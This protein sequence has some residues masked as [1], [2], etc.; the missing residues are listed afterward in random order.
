MRDAPKHNLPIRPTSFIGREKELTQIGSQLEESECRLLS[1][2]GVGGIGKTSLAIK[3][4]SEQVDHYSDG[5][6]LVE[7]ANM[8]D[9]DLLSQQVASVFGVTSHISS[10]DREEDEV[11]FDFLKD[12][13]LLLV[14]D[15]CEHLIEASAD[16]AVKMLNG[17]PFIK[18]LAT[19]RETL[20]IPGEQLFH[21]P[22]LSLPAG[23]S[24][25]LQLETFE[26]VQLFVDRAISVN[27][28]FELTDQ[29]RIA[30]L[31]ICRLLDGIPLAIELAAARVTVLSPDQIAERLED[32]FALLKSGQRTALP[33]HQTLQATMDWSYDLLNEEERSLFRQLSVFAGGWTLVS[34]ERV[35]DWP[36]TTGADYL[37]ELAHLVDKSLVVVER[38]NGTVRYKMLETVRQYAG[39]RLSEAGEAERVRRRHALYFLALAEDLEPQLR[40]HN[41]M[42]C[43]DLFEAEHEN[44]RSAMRRALEDGEADLALRLIATL[45]WFWFMRGYWKDVQR[46]LPM[47]LDL[48]TETDPLNR[49][50]AIIKTGG[51][52]IIR[53][54]VEGNVDLIEEALEIC[55]END[56][57][58]GVA[59]CFTFL[60]MVYGYRSEIDGAYEYLS[61]SVERFRKLGDEWG[62]AWSLRYLSF[63]TR[64][65]IGLDETKRL[66]E[67]SISRFKKIGDLWNAAHS[68]YLL[69]SSVFVECE[70]QR[71]EHAFSEG[72]QMCQTISDEVMGVHN[73]AGM[74]M[75]SFANGDLEQ[76]ESYFLEVSDVFQRIGDVN[77][78]AQARGFLA[79]LW[80]LMDDLNK[81]IGYLNE[82]IQGYIHLKRNLG[83]VT[84][85]V[86]FARVAIYQE[87]FQ[88]ATRLLGFSDSW[89]TKQAFPFSPYYQLSFDE[90]VRNS[91]EALGEE[92]FEQAWSKGQEMDLEGA[93][94]FAMKEFPS[95]T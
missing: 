14:M 15:N 84:S 64:R 40:G 35:V 85:L 43:L 41:Q 91:K 17:C 81:A 63:M 39:I 18:I 62:I 38:K 36:D 61:E 1:L 72:Y 48:K 42:D 52:E 8:A 25:D 79:E 58:E 83:I 12:K 68:L 82:S 3:Y 74:G 10:E 45:G 11:L 77:C 73:R 93:I 7:L 89:C 56:D 87:K 86:R 78:A 24:V 13:Q 31:N 95:S 28:E 37:E 2:I 90:L 67:E 94:G 21:V 92:A 55:R 70:F 5:V 27:H 47:A 6:W 53:V 50:K 23:E 44:L 33:R 9:P 32:R 69:G 16:F 20:A 59:W 54:N 4:A 80:I 22:A 71:A 88:T 76:A 66:Q 29:N 75:I 46:W 57:E 65:K 60:G 49:A 19:S 26:A 34:A 51:L 30:V